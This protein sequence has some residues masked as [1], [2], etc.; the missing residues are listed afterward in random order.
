MKQRTSKPKGRQLSCR[1]FLNCAE[2]KTDT[3]IHLSK[4]AQ[5]RSV[6]R[7]ISF[8]EIQ[9]IVAKKN[10]RQ[11]QSSVKGELAPVLKYTQKGLTVVTD[12]HSSTVITVYKEESLKNSGFHIHLEKLIRYYRGPDVGEYSLRLRKKFL[13]VK[14]AK[15]RDAKHG[16]ERSS[17]RKQ[18]V[19][20]RKG[21]S[22]QKDRKAPISM[23]KQSVNSKQKTLTSMKQ[24][25]RSETI[26]VKNETN[27]QKTMP[28]RG[29]K[30]QPKTKKGKKNQ[31]KAKNGKKK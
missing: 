29:K 6:E 18:R 27:A 15:A 11:E 8:H 3:D 1:R 28:M 9:S 10:P 4:H 7:G 23:K 25:M 5:E 31:P 19:A 14:I 17:I 13:T 26:N 22:T 16:I 2:T 21:V 30:N 20:W 24:H 12:A